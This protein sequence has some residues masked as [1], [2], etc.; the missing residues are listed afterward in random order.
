MWLD[1]HKLMSS[2]LMQALKKL[3]EFWYSIKCSGLWMKIGV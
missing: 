3:W 2:K 1:V